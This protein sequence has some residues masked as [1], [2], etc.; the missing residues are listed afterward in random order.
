MFVLVCVC[1]C[2]CA[3]FCVCVCL[4]K[5]LAEKRGTSRP[6]ECVFPLHTKFPLGTFSL[7][8]SFFN[9]FMCIQCALLAV[10][11]IASVTTYVRVEQGEAG[12]DVTLVHS[13]KCSFSCNGLLCVGRWT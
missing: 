13:L 5:E 11:R 6:L 10:C 1:V 9:S 4:E 7:F 12:R 3:R 8:F 2:V